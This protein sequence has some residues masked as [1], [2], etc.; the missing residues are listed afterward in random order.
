MLGQQLCAGIM[1]GM[2]PVWFKVALT[3]QR[4]W[5]LL[6]G[7][8]LPKPLPGDT[9]SLMQSIEM[10]TMYTPAVRGMVVRHGAQQ[11]ACLASVCVF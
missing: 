2:M 5:Q 11:L 8:P 10:L 4:T 1:P 7:V 6:R 3:W 9:G